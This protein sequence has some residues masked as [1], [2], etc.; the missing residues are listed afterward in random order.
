MTKKLTG[1]WIVCSSL[2]YSCQTSNQVLSSNLL[3]LAALRLYTLTNVY[4]LLSISILGQPWL[5]G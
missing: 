1:I 2:K 3:A 4:S 5:S